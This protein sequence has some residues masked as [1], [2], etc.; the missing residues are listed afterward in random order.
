MTFEFTYE[1]ENKKIT[2][3]EA[4]TLNVVKTICSNFKKWDDLRYS[5]IAQSNKLIDEIFMKSRKK[6]YLPEES[7]KSNVKMGKA[8]MLFQTQK[9]VI[10]RNIYSNVNAMF[11]VAGENQDADNNSNKQKA[12]LVDVFNKMELSKRLDK[13]IDNSL[14]Y[15]ELIAFVSWKKH[16]KEVRR[17][18]SFF[19]SLFNQDFK[20]LSKILGAKKDGKNFYIDTVTTYD[21]P[22]VYEVDPT[23]F[24][25]DISQEENFEDCPK[26]LRSYRTANEILSNDL[27]EIPKEVREQIKEAT[28][29]SRYSGSSIK[30]N[31]IKDNCIEILEAWGDLKLSDGTLLKNWHAVVVG[32]EYLVRFKKNELIEN[33][34]VFGTYIQDPETKRGISPLASVLDLVLQQEE[35]MNKT[36]NMQ[37]LSENPP[38]F[39]PE[40]FFKDKTTKL[41]PGKIITYDAGIYN[42]VPI[43]PMQ[44][45]SNIYMNDILSLDK[46]IAEVSGIF[47][48]MSGQE[49]TNGVTATEI[50]VTVQGQSNRLSM[51][52]DIINQYL[53]LPIV[54][55][56]A[57]LLANFKYGKE[58][59]YINRENKS[60]VIQIDDAIRQGQYEYTYQD[61]NSYAQRYTNA[62]TV[63]SAFEKFAQV[64]PMNWKEVFNWYWEQKGVENPERFLDDEENN[65]A[66]IQNDLVEQLQQ[67][68]KLYNQLL[69]LFEPEKND[70]LNISQ[71]EN[72]LQKQTP[73]N[74]LA[75]EVLLKDIKNGDTL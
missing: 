73:E 19:E 50:S 27:Y 58:T 35:L 18:I 30:R 55:K 4:E 45:S 25:F 75:D 57:N 53:I 33:P 29:G 68:P 17:P 36:Y 42:N 23:D 60:D 10:W 22:Y 51:L 65:I 47:P 37:A 56:T 12:M 48:N 11:D 72:D 59:I 5:N 34:F 54:K 52:L 39:A 40:D 6:S 21:N 69:G 63:A 64:L 70:N 20:N 15:G 41:Y 9:S 62:D 16:T 67:D 13:I 24:V 71:E 2:L 32:G 66:Q 7:W 26:I 31:R 74:S 1:H 61:R 46:T 49:Q 44:F 8:Y 14:F 28:S 3:K 43:T 38:T